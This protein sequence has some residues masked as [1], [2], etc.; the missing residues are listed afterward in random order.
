MAKRDKKK[1]KNPAGFFEH[2]LKLL[3]HYCYAVRQNPKIPISD[4]HRKYSTYSRRKS[5]TDALTK[6]Y[7]RKVI[8]GPFL[9]VNSGIEVLLLNDVDNPRKFFEECKKDKKTNLAVVSH[10]H[11]PLFL[12]KQGANTLQYHNSI[13]PNK[14][15]IKGKKVKKI[16]FEEKGTL[17]EDLYPH[18]WTEKHWETYYCM[19]SPRSIS[20]KEAGKKLGVSRVWARKYFLEVLE[21]CKVMTNFFPLGKETYSPLLV[22]LKTDYETG[23]VKGLKTLNRTTFLYKA[24]NTLILLMGVDPK[25]KAQNYLTNKFQRLEEMGLISDLHVSTPYDWH[26]AF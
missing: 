22:T 25:P 11:W 17:S 18:G 7:E 21:Q 3:L 13:L 12:C 1:K 24:E 14:G 23:I 9:F 20:F 26:K 15:K 10:G 16:F 5:V 4:I 6:A 2:Q 19:K 8:T